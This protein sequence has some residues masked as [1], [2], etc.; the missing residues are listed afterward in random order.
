MSR[1]GT[2][3]VV[4]GGAP[5]TTAIGVAMRSGQQYSGRYVQDEHVVEVQWQLVQQRLQ[6]PFVQPV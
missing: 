5:A 2:A 3:A 6:Y 1:V 4:A